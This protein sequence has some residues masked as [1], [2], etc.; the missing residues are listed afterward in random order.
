[1]RISDWSSDVCSS[2]L[3]IHQMVHDNSNA[4]VRFTGLDESIA[5]RIV[6]GLAKLLTD[7]AAEPDHPIRLRVEEGLAKLALALQQDP[8][9]Q[10]KVARVRDELLDHPA[11]KRWLAGLWETG[12]AALPKAA[13]DTEPVLARPHG[14]RGEE[15]G[16]GPARE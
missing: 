13:R 3:L 4:I 12:R 2:D 7:M 15:A 1:M 9:V 8:E 5:N 11:G 10:A 6:K 16:R 14:R